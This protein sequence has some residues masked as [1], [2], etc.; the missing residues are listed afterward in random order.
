MEEMAHRNY[1][2]LSG[3]EKQ[4]VLIARAIAQETDFLILDEPTNHLDI[5]Y[6]LQ[7]L[8]FVKNL[9]VT[10][11]A[12]LHD[13]NLA[14]MYCDR[15]YILK[16]GR[17]YKTGTPEEILTPEI[18]QAVYGIKADVFLHPLTNKVTITFLP[19]SMNYN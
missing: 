2:H 19:A 5:G 12:A 9:Q 7:I 11:L 8:D 4:R 14:A 13:L 18:I 6:Q 17:I 15:L 16:E 3:R 10:V 1:L